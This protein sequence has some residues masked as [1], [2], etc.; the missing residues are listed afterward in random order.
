MNSITS[1][2]TSKMRKISREQDN[3]YIEAIRIINN[4]ILIYEQAEC[5]FTFAAIKKPIFVISTN[6]PYLVGTR[7]Q[8]SE[9]SY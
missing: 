1:P 9:V 6:F 3:K 4:A 8:E 2:D 7:I 5:V